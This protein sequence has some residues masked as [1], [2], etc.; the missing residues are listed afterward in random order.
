MS[1]TANRSRLSFLSTLGMSFITL[2]FTSTLAFG[3][4]RGVAFKNPLL[5]PHG[6]TGVSYSI[7]L[8]TLLADPGVAPYRW[9]A[10][11]L[12]PGIVLDE[13]NNLLTGTPTQLGTFSPKLTVKDATPEGADLNHPATLMILPPP[14]EFTTTDLNLGV[15]KEGDT[16]T[17]D[18]TTFLT[19]P[20]SAKSFSAKGLP[21]WLTLNGSNGKLS[22]TPPYTP[23]HQFVGPYSGI[24]LTAINDT[25]RSDMTAHGTV[26]KK[27]VP[28]KWISNP[29]SLTDAFE[30]SNYSADTAQYVI[31]PENSPINYTLVSMTPPPWLNIGGAS[32]TLFGTPKRPGPIEVVVALATV[33][34]GVTYTDS[35]TFKF[36]VIHVNHAP[37]WL[38]NP[39]VLPKSNNGILVSQ[40]LAKSATDVDVNDKLTFSM[41]GADWAKIDPTTGIFSG[42]PGKS[43][44]GLN[45]FVAIVTDQDGATGSTQVQITIEKANEPPTWNNHPTLLPDGGEDKNY[46][47]VDLTKHVT[48]PDNDRVYFSKLDGP[49]WL[50]VNENGTLS[51]MPKVQDIGLNTFRV[52]VA[53]RIA[54][55]EDI[56]VVQIL[57]THT[58]HAPYWTMNPLIFNILEEKAVNQGISQYAMDVDN[59]PLVF[60][61][62]SGPSWAQLDSKGTFSGTP[63]MVHEGD[64]T[65]QVAVAD[66]SGEVREVTVIFKVQHVNHP[67]KWT[68]NPIVLSDATEDAEY[69]G[70]LLSFVTDSDLP[71]DTFRISKISANPSWLK[72]ADNGTISGRP[73][74]AD[75]GKQ[76]SFQVRV[77]DAANAEAVTTV[78]VTVL[79]INHAPRWSADPIP[80]ND[81]YED[82]AYSF[83]V[84]LYAS[85]SDGDILT[86]EK[87][88][89]PNWLMVSANGILSG[90][91]T[92]LD[93]GV[94]LTATF[95]VTDPKGLSASTKGVITVVHKNH[96]PTIGV[97]PTFTVKEREVAEFSLTDFVKDLDN[98]KLTFL[99]LNSADC[100]GWVLL[101]TEGKLT[102]DHPKRINVGV[103]ECNFKVD[104]GQLM[105]AATFKVVVEKNPR[106]PI[107]L[108]EPITTFEGKT[109]ETLNQSV[110]TLAKDLDGGKISFTKQ[111]GKDWLTV[112]ING[113]VTG[114]PKD[115]DLGAQEFTLR[116][117]NED[118]L[119]SDGT[120]VITVVPGTQLDLFNI[121]TSGPAKTELLWVID[122]SKWCDSTIKSLKANIDVFYSDLDAADVTHQNIL[123]SS[124]ID[125]FKGLP[126]MQT[127]GSRLFGNQNSD[128]VA[129]FQKRVGLA[130]SFGMCN[131]CSSSPLW[132]MFRF[133]EQLPTE[134]LADI[135]HK[136][137][138]MSGVPTDAII[139]THQLDHFKH[140][141]AK[142]PEPLLSYTPNDFARDFIT[143]HKQERKGYRVSAIA[144]RCP[145]LI[146]SDPGSAGPSNAYNVVV[147]K[148]KGKFYVNQ[149]HFDM[150]AT[151]HDYAKDVIFRAK[152]HGNNPFTL[153]K[154]PLD[155]KTIK[156]SL[157][158]VPLAGNSG[159]NSDQWNYEPS[160][161]VVTLRWDLI[162]TSQ[163]NTGDRITIEYRVSR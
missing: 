92:T 72:I 139:V 29:V 8:R 26:L 78:Q 14:P 87:V 95:K 133:L 156:V 96:S 22:G 60:S 142:L 44:L 117:T 126:I 101:S 76:Y 111:A 152:I 61:L 132:A 12:P 13:A 79:K 129:E 149:C 159:S 113:V 90:V 120:L 37:R 32:G 10:T 4:K 63:Q 3:A 162:D 125:K 145:D 137:Y 160:S 23:S 127:G 68:L 24:I 134:K 158:N 57:V 161:N 151:M 122:N 42:T 100:N 136:G 58:N 80:L 131:N 85:D 36:N 30:D 16:L 84:N 25:G 88:E 1:S 153:S 121:D 33:I 27:I 143:F 21:S 97:L 150:E 98:D 91:P 74:Q 20:S 109:N 19:D 38:A 128:L 115:V 9:A 118:G 82:T 28:A 46:G 77:L 66:P 50:T 59:D 93:I 52:K 41:T 89:G 130:G 54:T 35:T 112:S 2:F 17:L 65:F 56:A 69:S 15:T 31:N 67:P 71:N 7:D 138:I 154:R 45:T 147:Q 108:N 119:F 73:K 94:N 70:S 18:L 75:A 140:Y 141:T 103:H 53:D 55:P 105:A 157:G 83:P 6:T 39:I 148:T 99:I 124:D 163:L 102:L 106:A 110:A 135:Y 40:P 43:N 5:L 51:G 11:G 155:I 34:D 114:T 49:S 64:N 81:A 107:W 48:D 146:S 144:P 86:F 104:D 116:V 62:V 47:D 123:L